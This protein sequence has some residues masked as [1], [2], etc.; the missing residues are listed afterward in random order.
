MGT[1]KGNG[2]RENSGVRIKGGMFQGDRGS[3]R[4]A[5]DRDLQA[6]GLHQGREP[7]PRAHTTFSYPNADS[8]P[9]QAS[10]KGKQRNS[11]LTRDPLRV[12]QMRRAIFYYAAQLSL[13][14]HFSHM[15]N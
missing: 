5:G 3:G 8:A 2:D 11:F 1:Q 15:W 13:L 4:R 12:Y 6:S 14:Y 9:A 7:R 10:V